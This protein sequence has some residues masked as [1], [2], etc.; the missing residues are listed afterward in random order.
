MEHSLSKQ[1]IEAMSSEK[2]ITYS[3]FIYVIKLSNKRAADPVER[4]FL[5]VVFVL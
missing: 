1:W 4:Q 3:L 2:E 5:L